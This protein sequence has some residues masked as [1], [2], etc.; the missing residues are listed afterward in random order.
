MGGQPF[1]VADGAPV[2]G[3]PGQCALD[4]PPTGQDLEGVQVTGAIDNLQ[5]ERERGLGPGELACL[6]AFGPG[7]LDLGEGLAQVPQ[8]GPGR[9]AVLHAGRGDQHGQQQAQDVDGD[10]PLEALHLFARAVPAAG[11]RRPPRRP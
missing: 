1:V 10:V 7:E 11:P 9:V 4:H 5:G 2:A 6:A 3:D 8:Q